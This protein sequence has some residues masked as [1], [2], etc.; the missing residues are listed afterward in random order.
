MPIWHLTIASDGRNPPFPDE[1]SRRA[2]VRLFARTAGSDLALFCVVDD[3][4]HLVV[5][6]DRTCAGKVARA[7]ALGLRPLS[8]APVERARVREVESRAHAEWLVRYVLTQVCH[9]GVV[10][11][12]AL[13]TGSCFQDLVGARALPGLH[14]RLAAALPRLAQDLPA[15]AVGLGGRTLAPADDDALRAAGGARLVSAAASFRAVDPAL[16]GKAAAVVEARRAVA[17]LAR[18][19]GIANSEVAWA[20]KLTPRAARRLTAPPA[21]ATLLRAVRV[22]H[23]LV[24]LVGSAPPVPPTASKSHGVPRARG[25]SHGKTGSFNGP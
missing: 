21:P 6:G 16:A 19:A 14:L 20:L 12:P 13:R 7:V 1:A 4:V 11:H 18:E 5:L 24:E 22:R 10:E 25:A 17:Q 2:A 8:V 3:H 23:A 15:Q 9:H